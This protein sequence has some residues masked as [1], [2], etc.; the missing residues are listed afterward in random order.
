MFEQIAE[1]EKSGASPEERKKLGVGI[2]DRMDSRLAQCA[3][4]AQKDKAP[5]FISLIQ[6]ILA[7]PDQSTI[8]HDLHVVVDTV[9]NNDSVGIVVGR[10]V[11]SGLVKFL[12]EGVIKDNDLRKNV[13]KDS[14][15]TV[16]PRL[17]SYEEQ[18]ALTFSFISK[19]TL[20][21]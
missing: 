8:Q 18:V 2:F 7:R 6:E 5:A 11:L 9:V 1:A 20:Y 14:L 3:A 21:R 12:G 10:Q 13:V 4:L 17:V 16:Q 15:A 19:L